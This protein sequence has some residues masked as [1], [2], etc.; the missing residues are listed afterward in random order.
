L[1]TNSWKLED[2]EAL[3]GKNKIWQELEQE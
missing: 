2:L 3:E 1:K